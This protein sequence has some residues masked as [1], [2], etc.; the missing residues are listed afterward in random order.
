MDSL[1][2]GSNT[3][4]SARSEYGPRILEDVSACAFATRTQAAARRRHV[5]V[6]VRTVD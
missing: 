4:R 2:S 6:V 1:L 3:L 5:I